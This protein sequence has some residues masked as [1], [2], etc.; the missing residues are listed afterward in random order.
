MV[1]LHVEEPRPRTEERAG[2]DHAARL[3]HSRAAPAFD[4]RGGRIEPRHRRE[5]SGRHV[6]QQ[7]PVVAGSG[8][9]AVLLDEEGPRVDPQVVGVHD[10]VAGIAVEDDLER[11]VAR[12]R[13]IERHPVHAAVL[14]LRLVR[15]GV[16]EVHDAG[17]AGVGGGVLDADEVERTER[18]RLLVQL[19]ARVAIGV[20]DGH[21][22]TR[23]GLTLGDVVRRGVAVTLLVGHPHGERAVAVDRA[24][25]VVG[26]VRV[27]LRAQTERVLGQVDHRAIQAVN[28]HDVLMVD[29][30]ELRR[31]D[32]PASRRVDGDGHAASRRRDPLLAREVPRRPVDRVHRGRAEVL[33][34]LGAIHGVARRHHVALRV[35]GEVRDARP[36]G[37]AVPVR[38]LMVREDLESVGG[39]LEDADAV[40][41][42]GV[43]EVGTGPVAR[44]D[45]RRDLHT[46]LQRHQHRTRRSGSRIPLGDRGSR[47]C[48]RHRERRDQ[49]RHRTP[50]DPSLSA[51]DRW[52]VPRRNRRA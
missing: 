9:V 36:G 39:A 44:A 43:L 31:L 10:V 25:E 24:L 42:T 17:V 34:S 8:V 18:F 29:R 52:M 11:G 3:P 38:E 35:E 13:R 6:V 5:H 12:V 22:M 14:R 49:H 20:R 48:G 30:A 33:V 46:G 51:R 27:G 26:E 45:D 16:R 28:R 7:D 15:S 21:E 41:H 19:Q 1:R 4:R 2:V 32:H 50:H 40:G 37:V 23:E 47:P